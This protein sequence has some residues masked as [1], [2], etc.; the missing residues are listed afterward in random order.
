MSSNV[1]R[2]EKLSGDFLLFEDGTKE[3]L[4]MNDLIGFLSARKR[5]SSCPHCDY[6]G[7]WEI[8]MFEADSEETNPKLEIFVLD[9]ASGSKHSTAALTCPNCGHFAQVAT[10]KIRQF[11]LERMSKNA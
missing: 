10:Y 2:G 11:M 6:R 1:G 4:R 9:T 3:P 7:G 5:S 8:A